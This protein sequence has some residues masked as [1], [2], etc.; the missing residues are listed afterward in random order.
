MAKKKKKVSSTSVKNPAKFVFDFTGWE[1]MT[2]EQFHKLKTDARYFYY[3]HIPQS[4]LETCLKKYLKANK[5]NKED[6]AAIG[7]AYM[8]TVIGVL[9]KMLESGCPDYNKKE[10][11]YWESLPGT[12]G[13]VRPLSEAIRERVEKMLEEGRAIKEE[14][15]EQ[16]EPTN[17]IS[18]QDR[19]KAQVSPLLESFEGF[20]DDWL[21]GLVKEKDFDPYRDMVGYE[22]KIKPAH[23]KLILDYF[24]SMIEES[25][26]VLKF[27]DE[28]IREAYEH[29]STPKQRK[30]FASLFEKIEKACNMLIQSGKAKRK[31]RKPKEISNEKLVARLKYKNKDTEYSLVSIN[32]TS[33]IGAQELWVFNTKTRK[34]GRYI[35]DEYEGP[36]TVKGSTIQGFNTAT[37]VQKTLRK[38]DEQLREFQ[39]SGK[40][41]LRK[42]MDNIKSKES[43]LTGRIN[44]DTILLKNLL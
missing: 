18:I 20:F 37:S 8:P 29:L 31:P 6:I 11:E 38:P 23:A 12:S 5:Y 14:V 41:S 4:D 44:A 7:R 2:G 32:P 1:D 22:T 16:V 24:T 9:C 13:S 30:E 33:I 26:E 15:E 36:L 43:Q 34:L 19:M 10:N 28:D 21:D 35:A 17:V 25:K 3:E 42:F 39:S 27:K 40:V